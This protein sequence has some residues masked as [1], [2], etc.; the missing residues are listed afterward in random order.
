VIENQGEFY[1]R[2]FDMLSMVTTVGTPGVFLNRGL[3]QH[4]TMG[5]S[6][7]E[8]FVNAATGSAKVLTGRLDLLLS[9]EP[10]DGQF[11]GGSGTHLCFGGTTSLESTSVIATSG[12]VR[13]G[14]GASITIGGDYRVQ[15]GGGTY[16]HN[17]SHLTFTGSV[18]GVGDLLEL[19]DSSSFADFGSS[20]LDVKQ[21]TSYGCH[22]IVGNVTVRSKLEWTRGTMTGSGTTVIADGAKAVIPLNG[23]A[24]LD[25]RTLRVEPEGTVS[26]EGHGVIEL[27]NGAVIENQGEF[28]ARPFDMLSMVT[29][30]GTPGVFYNNDVGAFIAS[31]PAGNTGI[32]ITFYNEGRVESLAGALSFYDTYTQTGNSA[33]TRLSG[34]SISSSAPLD[35]QA[36][37]LTGSGDIYGGVI[38]GGTLSP[39]LSAAGNPFGSL[40]I[41]GI[42]S[43]RSGTVFQVQLGG[44]T[45][46]AFDRV[47]VDGP[48]ILDGGLNVSLVNWTPQL[49][50]Q[51][52]IIDNQSQDL[53]KGEFVDLS[54]GAAIRIGSVELTISYQGGTGNDV[55][56]TAT[57]FVVTSNLDTVDASDD[58]TTFTLREAILAANAH[59]GLDTIVF[60]IP[61][62][63]VHTIRPLSALP[64]ITDPVVLDGYSQPGTRINTLE[65]GD[66]AVLLIELDGTNAGLAS[67]LT[68]SAGK[69]TVK[70]LAINS[71][72]Y[73]GIDITANGNNVIAGNFI[74]TDVTGTLSRGNGR[75]GYYKAAEYPSDVF[76]DARWYA[77]IAIHG[78]SQ[79]NRVGTDGDEWNDL[80]ERNIISGN[81]LIGVRIFGANT[82]HNV[83]AGNYI[84]TD[85]SGDGA[86][87]N[88]A[89]GVNLSR[90]AKFNRIGTDG[91]GQGDGA[92][93]NII[94]GNGE[95]YPFAVC[96]L[97]IVHKGT[98]NNVVAGNY[99]GTNA[100]GTERLGNGRDGIGIGI[101]YGPNGNRIGSDLDGRFDDNERNVISGNAYVG[102][103]IIGPA[104]GN[105][106]AG[107]YI[108]TTCTGTDPMGNGYEANVYSIYSTPGGIAIRG[109][110]NNYV[111]GNVVSGNEITYLGWGGGGVGISLRDDARGNVVAGNYVGV[112]KTGTTPLP[113]QG[114]G[115]LINNATGNFVGTDGNGFDD[116][117]EGNVIS[118]NGDGGVTLENAAFG[119][120]VA[121]N[122]IGL[123]V[124]GTMSLGNTGHGILVRQFSQFNRIG[125]NGDAISDHAERN[126]ISGNSMSGVSIIGSTTSLNVVAGNLI[127]AALD[128]TPLGNGGDGVR[129]Q[130]GAQANQIGAGNPCQIVVEAENFTSRVSSSVNT[131]QIIPDERSGVVPR[132]GARDGKYLQTLPDSGGASGNPGT[133]VGATVTYSVFV[134]TSGQYRL[135]ARWDGHDGASDSLYASILELRDGAGGQA[136][137]YR[138]SHSADANFTTIPWDGVGQFEGTSTSGSNVPTLWTFGT[139]GYYTVSFLMR[140]DGSALD[141]F[142]LQPA[143][144]L[145]PVGY[146]PPASPVETSLMSNWIAFNGGSGVSVLD[147]SSMRNTIRANNILSNG[148]LGVDLGGDGVTPNDPGDG[149]TGPNMRQ[150]FPVLRLAEAGTTTRV[151]GTLNGQVGTAF[152]IDF[153]ANA[154]V[155]SSGHGEGERYLGSS[156]V[157]VDDDGEVDFEVFL[158]AM[159]QTSDWISAIA[160]DSA[161]NTSELSAAKACN[162]PPIADAGGPYHGNEGTA[163][164]FDASKSADVDGQELRYRWD[165]DGDGNWDTP[166]S[167]DATAAYAWND[168][169]SGT[170]IVAVS[171]GLAIATATAGVTIENVA[172]VVL[173]FASDS[174]TGGGAGE[175]VPIT[176]SATFTDAGT[177]DTH[178]AVIQWGDG[179]SSPAIIAET[180]GAGTISAS[181]AYPFG[182]IYTVTLALNDDDGGMTTATAM[183]VISGVGVVDNVLYVIGTNDNDHIEISLTQERTQFK[184]TADF[185]ADSSVRF[186]DAAGIQRI[187]VL[188]YAGRDVVRIAPHI[189]VTTFVD[190]GEESDTYLVEFG[191]VGGETE[192]ADSGSVGVDTLTV[193]GTMGPDSI[194]V[195]SHRVDLQT[196]NL[197]TVKHRGVDDLTVDGAGGNDTIIIRGSHT[198]ILGGAG[199]DA[200][201]V[202]AS[203]IDLEGDDIDPLVL[204]G[205]DGSDL[206]FVFFGDLA[207]PVIISDSGLTGTDSLT[208]YGDAEES[209]LMTV[210]GTSITRGDEVIRFTTAVETLT[211]DTG[212]GGD[213]VVIETKSVVP[214]VVRGNTELAV[215][216]TEGPDRIH[217]TP[218]ENPGEIVA[219]LNDV[220][221]GVCVTPTRLIAYG[222][223]GDDDI[224]VAG[225]ITVAS[226]LYGENGNDRLRGGAGDD[227]LLGGD[228]DDALVGGSGRDLLIGGAGA[229]RIVGNADDDILI[230]GSVTYA[231]QK[232]AR[233][234]A[235]LAAI[236]REWCSSHAYEVRV[237]NL[238]GENPDL[239]TFKLRENENFFLTPSSDAPTVFDD[240]DRDLLTGSAG[241]DWFMFSDTEDKATDLSDKEFADILDFIMAEL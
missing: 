72:A 191:T 180:D 134:P 93:R 63:G 219:W 239:A 7:I 153:Y 114:A 139:P 186:V 69:S 222:R 104:I 48:V 234:E 167:S 220:S 96:G 92:E 5:Y 21:L 38:N 187:E 88:G 135:Y 240:F 19:G 123:D 233:H 128:L 86:L 171:D 9:A 172:P 206:Y 44:L 161:G 13:F 26:W 188:T 142:V 55:T 202:E 103:D 217:F 205:Q 85:A 231:D 154:V 33:E 1:A 183:A 195:T 53:V 218:G 12:D 213:R 110:Q 227:I 82:N 112:D 166:W 25:G 225:S 178:V 163:V 106:V 211:V 201:T 107:N 124:M 147:D 148:G 20:S 115:I 59:P 209:D 228:G 65:V 173:E 131:W 58:A 67:G 193:I 36:G 129:I 130:Q 133:W 232:Y 87:A 57:R 91:D 77:G 194:L 109:G 62:S 45:P 155:D 221:L 119:N 23:T 216:G 157:I 16:I 151:V 121:G 64:A 75:E 27:N 212:D 101:A 10:Q 98:D 207:V 11:L 175:L 74:G 43:Q 224:Q 32:S 214:M 79:F 197:E 34:G 95:A 14:W 90:S 158:T 223:G 18:Q 39:G 204:D 111:V 208:V 113:N 236:M 241:L 4:D 52:T 229:D 70:G 145:A 35:I 125:T 149:D 61:G 169:W 132:V 3:M 60:D 152:H 89:V 2:P 159:T 73:H 66:N 179:T 37:S 24:T 238:R 230:A 30:V 102:V 141:A 189:G 199:D 181:H 17:G 120:V 6:H 182:G 31:S 49:G 105:V 76:L 118:A 150:N 42:Y 68:I 83:V 47:S 94:S 210:S 28:Y 138:Y 170:V 203:G 15:A 156:I 184:V 122:R 160:T 176:A 226:W 41:G 84:G 200:I 127:G 196:T 143:T 51:F 136:D 40:Q 29:T 99:I 117:A 144:M 237:N 108:G 235:A 168:D 116:E 174:P 165:F 177:A 162:T 81:Q 97:S 192:V 8:G 56:L 190:G 22:F 80:A 71:F 137:W 100:D 50:Q 140:E 185:L 146:G 198:T 54:E 164:L 126:I 215:E 78:G 46:N